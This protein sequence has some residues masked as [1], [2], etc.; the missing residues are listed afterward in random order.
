MDA[1]QIR[2]CEVCGCV[3]VKANWNLDSILIL[4][5]RYVYL[6]P[7]YSGAV[8]VQA[9]HACLKSQLTWESGGHGV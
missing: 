5:E 6:I 7:G 1:E 2:P 9:A 3:V 8:S 4:C